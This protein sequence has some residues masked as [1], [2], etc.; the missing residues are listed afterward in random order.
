MNSKTQLSLLF[1]FLA[2]V[3]ISAFSYFS[4]SDDEITTIIETVP[5]EEI[6]EEEST[7]TTLLIEEFPFLDVSLQDFIS[8]VYGANIINCK[9]KIE[10]AYSEP[11]CLKDTY[12][13]NLLILNEKN[14]FT[15]QAQTA[16]DFLIKNRET[17]TQSNI[18]KLLEVIEYTTLIYNLEEQT[19]LLDSLYKE[20]FNSNIKRTAI[21]CYS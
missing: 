18:N 17:L 9:T 2:V 6:I 5:E 14:T 8:E 20:R 7:T 13:A 19:I 10:L 1:I 4:N 3:S 21:F 15:N 16:K 11:E 12:E